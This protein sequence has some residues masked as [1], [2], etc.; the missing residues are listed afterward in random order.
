MARVYR[1]LL[2]HGG[3]GPDGTWLVSGNPWDVIGARAAGLHAA[4]IRRDPQA[5]F[6]PW[7]GRPD[8]VVGDL[9]ELAR[10]PAF[11]APRA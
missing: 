10:Q 3:A 11:T 5:A 2:D 8:L 4:W 1:F 6:D 9:V 7:G